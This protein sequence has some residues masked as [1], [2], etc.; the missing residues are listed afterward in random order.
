[1]GLSVELSRFPLVI[2]RLGAAEPSTLSALSLACE[3]YLLELNRHR[4]LFACIHD[5]THAEPLGADAWQLVF[6]GAIL[7]HS[8]P[9]KCVAQAV[10]VTT[11]SLRGFATARSVRSSLPHRVRVAASF[12]AALAWC[13]FQLRRSEPQAV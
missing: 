8:L 2:C 10:A 11:P 5:W 9:S 13:S 1:M 7:S 3:A 12:D 6:D 4:G